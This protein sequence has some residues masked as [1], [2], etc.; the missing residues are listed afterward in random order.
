MSEPEVGQVWALSDEQA[1][2]ASTTGGRI[3]LFSRY[4][5]REI[6]AAAQGFR[7]AWKYVRSSEH[8]CHVC[9]K[10]AVVSDSENWFCSEHNDSCQQIL[11]PGDTH[12]KSIVQENRCPICGYDPGEVSVILREKCGNIRYNTC[13]YCSGC[14]AV[15][16]GGSLPKISNLL[17]S[18]G[19]MFAERGLETP[20]AFCG[21]QVS[22][23][24]SDVFKEI[25]FRGA[26]GL[27]RSDS[28]FASVI[29]ARKSNTQ[30]HPLLLGSCWLLNGSRCEVVGYEA[31]QVILSNN[32]LSYKY[33]SPLEIYLNAESLPRAG[34]KG[35]QNLQLKLETS[36]VWWR[37]GVPTSISGLKADFLGFPYVETP[38]LEMTV[39]EFCR[40]HLFQTD[41][42][43]KSEDELV[44]MD[45]EL[46][47]LVAVHDTLAE[48]KSMDDATEKFVGL[49]VLRDNYRKLIRKT[50][51]E[52]FL[53]GL[54]DV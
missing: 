46:W 28:P 24:L 45:G 54:S 3:T 33:C 42:L 48:L 12:Y 11:L 43:F 14:W 9:R 35:E 39:T 2:V 16:F 37:K 41:L 44:D 18:L 52:H 20:V 27:S 1:V 31:S 49:S 50:N 4:G 34:Q 25:T 7:H 26:T 30:Q 15:F 17:R 21:M 47:R 32:R 8:E 38:T 53:E 10:V 23:K 36:Q 13:P 40:S 22:Q 6:V 29:K 5:G 19:S 51:Y